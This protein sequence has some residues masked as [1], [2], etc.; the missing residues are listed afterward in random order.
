MTDEMKKYNSFKFIYID[1][2][3]NFKV[4][5]IVD[6]QIEGE[7]LVGTLPHLSVYAVV[8]E[9]TVEEPK[10]NNP[11]TGDSVIINIVMLV[12]CLMGLTSTVI[13]IKKHKLI[14]L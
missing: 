1:E 7:Y 9:T 10:D 2:N 5:D 12:L 8:G 3:N 13:Y 11:K 6:V 14:R 4:G